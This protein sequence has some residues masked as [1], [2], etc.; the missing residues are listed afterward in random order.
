L[1]AKNLRSGQS[2][3]TK[4]SYRKNLRRADRT[5][6]AK[7]GAY[8][9]DASER[10]VHD[11]R[12]TT[13]RMLA[14]VQF[15]PKELRNAKRVAEYCTGLEKL[16]R[17]NAKTRDLDIIIDKVDQRNP[18][19]QHGELL[20]R[21]AKLRESSLQSG[22]AY[23]R[24]IEADIDLPV[25]EKNFSS[26]VLQKRFEKLSEKY[27]SRI[28]ERLPTVLNKPEEKKE[29][30][31][32]REDARRLRYV[33]ELGDRKAAR[34]QLKMLRLWQEVLGEIHDS[35]IFIEHFDQAEKSQEDQLLV[36]GETMI[37]EGNY[38]RFKKLAKG[39]LRL[40]S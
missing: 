9:E 11:L 32:L 33:L 34:K 31:M 35:D 39:P 5:L 30:H 6:A 7:I 1:S 14:A 23:A 27:A 15:L 20:K 36:N 37:R 29:L 10:N 40:A 12:T 18:S 3:I 16:M 26:A 8:L 28:T 38:R 24:A 22:R 17:S 2:T 4:G 13:R 19:G 25:K 21:L